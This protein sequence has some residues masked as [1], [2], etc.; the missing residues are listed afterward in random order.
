MGSFSG[1]WGN[2]L[3]PR[4]IATLI[5]VFCCFPVHECSHA[6]MAAKLGDPTG[7]RDGRIT[8]NPFKHLDL[9]GTVMLLAFGV[10]YAKAVPVNTYNFRSP[11]KDSSIVSLAGPM[12]NLIMAVALLFV[13]Y[14][15]NFM[16][17]T[18]TGYGS[19]MSFIIYCLRY[20]AYINFGLTVLNLIPLPPMDG[21]RVFMAL[22]PYRF[23]HRVAR[24]ERYSVYLMLGLLLVFNFFNVSPIL[25]AAQSLYN[26]VDRLYRVLLLG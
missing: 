14:L 17:G 3:I 6:W 13:V 10:G 2:T 26:S 21:Y 18:D 19:H 5:I 8:L 1:I 9:W 12:S 22:V 20:A 15:I 7:E 24:I 23:Y 16:T 4:L 25:S 11:R